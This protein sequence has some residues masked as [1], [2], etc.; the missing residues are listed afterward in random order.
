[1]VGA[2]PA[3]ALGGHLDD[4]RDTIPLAQEP[5]AGCRFNRAARRAASQGCSL[6]LSQQA[7]RQTARP[8]RLNL[9]GDEPSKVGLADAFWR[10]SPKKFGPGGEKRRPVHPV[11][12]VEGGHYAAGADA[13]VMR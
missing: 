8:S 6:D 3:V 11:E 10:R 9:E 7:F 12:S 2:V 1:M 5:P 4:V 13:T